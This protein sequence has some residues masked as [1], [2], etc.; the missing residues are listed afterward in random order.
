MK[1]KILYM[2]H[3]DWGWIKQRPHFIAEKLNKTFDV[4]VFYSYARNRKSLTNNLSEVNKYPIIPLPMKRINILNKLNLTIQKTYFTIVCK[5]LRP[6][7]IWITHPSL[8]DYLTDDIVKKHKII[9]DCM[10]DVLEFNYPE[11]VKKELKIAEEELL[12]HADRVFVSSEYLQ[13]KIIRRGCEKV[14]TIL[15]RN[16]YNGS[17]IE[18]ELN[19][20]RNNQEPFRIAY[21]GTI[22]DW[23]NFDFILRSLETI[24]NIEYHFFG[25]IDCEV[26]AHNRILFRGSVKHNELYDHIKDYDC[27]MM[28]FKINELILAVDPVKLYEYVN[29]S[30]NIITVYYKEIERFQ[31]F[32]HFYSTEEEFILTIENL[33]I[34]PA[35]KYNEQQRQSFLKENT[36]DERMKVILKGIESIDS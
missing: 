4:S 18:P 24:P 22:S 30:K 8:Y 14:K 21:V 1:K 32:V 3:V 31:E 7:Y 36:W 28:P 15:V 16:G 35:I 12:K 25:P 5:W 9:Y 23:V 6:E 29:F 27:L 13:N 26:P 11:R 34:N 19:E 20:V 17:I 2:M 33:K 10:D